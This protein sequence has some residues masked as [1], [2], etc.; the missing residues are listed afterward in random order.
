M[1]NWVFQD[2]PPHVTFLS[3]SR[4]REHYLLWLPTHKGNAIESVG[5]LAGDHPSGKLVYLG[6]C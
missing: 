1:K 4:L 5:D 2:P 3:A 6:V